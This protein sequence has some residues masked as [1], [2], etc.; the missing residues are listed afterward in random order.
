MG[1]NLLGSFASSSLSIKTRSMV[2]RRNYFNLRPLSPWLALQAPVL[3]KKPL[4]LEWTSFWQNRFGERSYWR[5][6]TRYYIPTL[7]DGKLG[8]ENGYLGRR[9]WRPFYRRLSH[10]SCT[11]YRLAHFSGLLREHS[12]STQGAL[13][14]TQ[15]V[16]RDCLGSTQGVLRDY[17]G[18]AYGLLIDT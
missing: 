2:Q 4:V 15:G 6:S 3:S 5:Y 7:V 12:G 14:G 13:R 8:A 16:P 10:L 1:L 11:W 17:L 18:T 9:F